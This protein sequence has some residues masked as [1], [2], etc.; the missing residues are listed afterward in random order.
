MRGCN[1]SRKKQVPMYTMKLLRERN[2][3]LVGGSTLHP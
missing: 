2:R 3:V 1:A